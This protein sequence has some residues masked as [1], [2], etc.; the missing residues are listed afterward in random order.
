M[1]FITLLAFLVSYY[2]NDV[3]GYLRAVRTASLTERRYLPT[4]K[5]LNDDS[6]EMDS[7]LEE[8]ELKSVV[9]DDPSTMVVEL[10]I[11][12]KEL[13]SYIQN[14]LESESP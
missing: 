14:L 13:Q 7:D 2:I 4:E 9:D 1:N 6:M 5:R 3:D 12:S 10:N 11:S 8:V